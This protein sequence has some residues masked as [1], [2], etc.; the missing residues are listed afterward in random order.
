M[1]W[2]PFAEGDYLT[3]VVTEKSYMV[4][5]DESA[6]ATTSGVLLP[7]GA[8]DFAVPA[9]VTH[10]ALISSVSGAVAAVWKS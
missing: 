5:G 4:T 2:G 3:I 6:I 7:A 9:G 10:V 1:A 8:Y